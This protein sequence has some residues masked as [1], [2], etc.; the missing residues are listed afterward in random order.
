MPDFD[1]VKLHKWR[2]KL[3][4]MYPHVCM[5]CGC[6]IGLEGDH[7]KPK[8]LFPKLAYDLKN[9]QILCGPRGN[10]CNQKKGQLIIDY[11]P[12]KTRACYMVIRVIKWLCAVMLAAFIAY[13][14]TDLSFSELFNVI[15]SV[16]L[17]LNIFFE[18]INIPLD[19]SCLRGACGLS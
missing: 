16:F 10:S 6:E 5:A 12:W 1:D 2:S 7:V 11:R 18:A 4:T 3:F 15:H 13:Q 9:G 8:S 19:L 17:S 14:F